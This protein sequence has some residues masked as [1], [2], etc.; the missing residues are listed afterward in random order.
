MSNENTNLTTTIGA[1]SP[2]DVP[3][4]LVAIAM[5]N[6][7]PGLH[8]TGAEAM[9]AALA[10][11]LPLYGGAIIASA[12]VEHYQRQENLARTLT[13]RV[14]RASMLLDMASEAQSVANQG[15]EPLMNN[16]LAQMLR[17]RAHR[18]A[19]P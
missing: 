8:D 11:V 4:A 9:R 10:A 16:K 19:Q 5:D 17:D 3:E 14:A 18:E 13:T 15:I 2:D 1:M 7:L 12:G 6:Y